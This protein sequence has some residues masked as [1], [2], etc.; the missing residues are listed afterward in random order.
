MVMSINQ[1][2]DHFCEIFRLAAEFFVVQADSDAI[3]ISLQTKK[4]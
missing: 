3:E 2:V 1:S 4:D